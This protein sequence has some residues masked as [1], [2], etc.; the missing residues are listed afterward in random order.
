MGL[1]ISLG[2]ES[3]RGP[4]NVIYVGESAAEAR[5][6]E[7]RSV[8]PWIV[9]LDNPPVLR[10]HNSFAEA[11]TA[12]LVPA[13]QPLQEAAAILSL[14]GEASEQSTQPDG[15]IDESQLDESQPP[16]DSAPTKRKK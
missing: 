2:R 15:A 11:N 3:Q 7:A 10:K 5:A 13:E 12:N 6:S 16:E 1:H 4:Y 14:T 8:Y 9:R